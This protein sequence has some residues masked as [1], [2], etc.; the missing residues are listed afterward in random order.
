MVGFRVLAWDAGALHR[1]EGMFPTLWHEFAVGLVVYWHLNVAATRRLRL[2]LELGLVG[3][4]VLGNWAGD[5]STVAAAGFGLV[6]ILLR[7]W[8]ERASRLGWLDPLRACGRRCYSIYL[9]HLP[10]LSVGSSILLERGLTGFWSRSLVTLP[11]VAAA[12]VA[13]SWV[14]YRYVESPFRILP[15]L[16]SP[17]SEDGTVRLPSGPGLGITIDPE[18]IRGADEVTTSGTRP[19]ASADHPLRISN[20]HRVRP[21][22]SS[23]FPSQIARGECPPGRIPR[24]VQQERVQVDA[25]GERPGIDGPDRP[26]LAPDLIVPGRQAR[27]L[28]QV[29]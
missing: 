26:T 9:V 28:Q 10:I 14:F 25:G 1:L 19:P 8:D 23:L 20:R 4:A 15:T 18:F 13:A 22:S 3:L 27:D 29:A 16:S 17:R 21:I 11:A 5:G 7:P 2:G 6:M 12:S 24:R